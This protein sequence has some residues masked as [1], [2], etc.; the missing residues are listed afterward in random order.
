MSPS[1]ERIEALGL[2]PVDLADRLVRTVIGHML[3]DGHFHAD[4]HPGN[5]LLLDDGALGLIDFGATGR[6]NSAQRLALLDMT[7]AALRG[8]SAALR[9]GI[10]RVAIVG[11]DVQDA[12]LERALSQFIAENLRPGGALGVDTLND[13]IPLL[14][15]FDIRLPPELTTVFRTLVPP[16]WHRPHHQSRLF[17]PRQ[18][19]AS[20]RCGRPGRT[21]D[22]ERTRPDP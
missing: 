15:G 7:A 21:D 8:D 3:H 16:G 10:E 18:P 17:A 11:P 5:V 19:P 6:L 1:R 14:A 2:N 22:R 13:L 4:P 20:S 9:D 12:A